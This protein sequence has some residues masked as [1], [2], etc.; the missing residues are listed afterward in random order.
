MNRKRKADDSSGSS[1]GLEGPSEKKPA[2]SRPMQ[3]DGADGNKHTIDSDEEEEYTATKDKYEVLDDEEIE[4]QEDDTIEKDGEVQI[5]P[6]NLKEEREEGDFS[7]DGDFIWKKTKDINDAWLDNIDWVKVK[8]VKKAEQMRKDAEDEAEDEAEAAYNELAVYKS[9]L[10][11]L[12][13]TET[14]AKAIRRLSGAAGGPGQ[15]KIVLQKQRK[16]AQKLKKNQ[17]L[18]E[19]EERFQKDR[20]DMTKLTGMADSILTR[21][22]NMEIYEETYEK[23]AYRLKEAEAKH[24]LA[25]TEVPEDM[26]DDDALDMFA[27]TF[28]GSSK[29]KATEPPKVEA[30]E[31]KST[32]DF[33]S[34]VKWEYKWDNKDGSEIHGPHSSEEMLKWQENGFF[35]KG[36]FVRK[37]G[38]VGKEFLDGK[39]I[40]FDLYV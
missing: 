36:V 26:E 8:E 2:S 18:T 12:K 25:T 7:K 30:E 20:D 38:D 24:K 37:V 11:L 13:P 31:V 15:Q 4:G 32:I 22:G 5:T 39:R 27:D 1:E 6:F 34:E 23:I 9:V 35:D 28:D 40:D 16:I 10:A 33:D 17:K 19:D 3:G 21:S 14:V 29:E